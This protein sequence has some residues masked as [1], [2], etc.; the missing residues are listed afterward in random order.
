LYKLSFIIYPYYLQI[1]MM[2]YLFFVLPSISLFSSATIYLDKKQGTENIFLE[3][4]ETKTSKYG[5]NIFYTN[6]TSL[7]WG[8]LEIQKIFVI[9]N[10]TISMIVLI[11][12]YIGYCSEPL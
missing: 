5:N 6:G 12:I 9:Y 10:I 4:K 7:Q 8:W 2:I 1:H 3:L 11:Y